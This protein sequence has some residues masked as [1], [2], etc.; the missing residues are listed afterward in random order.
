MGIGALAL[1]LPQLREARGG[2][3]LQRFHLLVTRY[4]ESMLEAGIHLGVVVWVVAVAARPEAMQLGFTALFP[5]LSTSIS[6]SASAQDLLWLSHD[7]ISF[8]RGG[9]NNAAAPSPLQWLA[10]PQTLEH[11]LDSVLFLSLLAPVPSPAG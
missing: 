9:Q 10:R 2:A 6:A 4:V 8:D 5:S 3:Q 7:P 11:L 1:L